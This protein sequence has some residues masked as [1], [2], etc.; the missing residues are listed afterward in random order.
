MVSFSNEKPATIW[1][2]EGLSV[3][4]P[5]VAPWMKN[6]LGHVGPGSEEYQKLNS[7]NSVARRSEE[8]RVGIE[9]RSR[10]SQYHYTKKNT[11]VARKS[12]VVQRH[13]IMISADPSVTT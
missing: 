9:C 12:R 2:V 3:S 6:R 11:T 5:E 8:R 13:T 1:L 10:W 4:P 7:A